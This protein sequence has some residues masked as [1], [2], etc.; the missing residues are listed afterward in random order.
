MPIVDFTQVHL[1][2][3]FWKDRYL[4]NIRNSIP[5]IIKRFESTRI[6]AVKFAFKEKSNLHH[7]AYD[8][9]VAKLIEAIAYVLYHNKNQY[10]EF[11]S[12]CDELIESI[13]AHQLENGYF[14]SYYQLNMPDQLFC[15]RVDHE[16]YNLGHLIEAAIAYHQATKKDQLLQVVYRYI[17]YVILRFVRRKDTLFVTPGHEEIELALLKL[18]D[19]TKNKK[20]YDLAAFFLEQRA[21]NPKDCY[22]DFANDRYAQDNEK[23]R[24]LKEVEGHAVRA[25]YLYDAMAKYASI[26]HDKKIIRALKTLYAD[27]LKKQYI[28]G[29]IGSY[30]VGEIFTIPYDLPNLTAYSESC[31]S[32]GEMMFMLDLYSLTMKKTIHDQIERILYNGFLSSTSLDGKAFFYENPLEIR[33]KEINKETSILPIWRQKLPSASRVELFECSCCPP[34]IARFVASIAR[35][36][37]FTDR[38]DI[39]I[40]QFISSEMTH[41]DCKIIMQSSYP[42]EFQV[43]LSVQCLKKQKIYVRCPDYCQQE[44]V[45][46]PYRKEKGYLLFD[47]EEGN[48]QIKIHFHTHATLLQ[49]HPDNVSDANKVAFSYGPIIYCL[50]GIDH[51][52]ALNSLYIHQLKDLQKQFKAEYGM[53]TFQ[54]IG[55]QKCSKPSSY[56]STYRLKKCPLKLIPYYAFA[57]RGETDM[58]VWINKK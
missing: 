49:A 18:Y 23:I 27:L 56:S 21:N 5:N 3:G 36:I 38:D 33:L 25:M 31:A 53:F 47:L 2:D 15:K 48:H 43:M 12:L 7:R 22:E 39:Y 55:Y 50:E 28:T 45:N 57:N 29:S 34:N 46:F 20:F 1:L 11:E 24:N 35:Y 8:S 42:L 4:L 10:P 17:D 58:L 13:A 54:V 26:N 44:T 6:A 16:L 19:Y 9:D 41:H 37:Y 30:R 14:N 32:I 51:P 40:N 52:C